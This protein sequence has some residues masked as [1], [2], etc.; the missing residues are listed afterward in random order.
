MIEEVIPFLTEQIIK[1]NSV[2]VHCVYGQSRSAVICAAY[3]ISNGMGFE[4]ALT[5]MKQ[6]HPNICINPGFLSQL[7]IFSHKMKYS[8]QYEM[9]LNQF[10]M[11]NIL[12]IESNPCDQ[13][14]I[15]CNDCLK[16][17]VHLDDIINL[18]DEEET[19]K[20]SI[21]PF[22]DP[23]WS[24]YHSLHSSLSQPCNLP[25]NFVVCRPS[26][27]MIN[28]GQTTRIQKKEKHQNKKRRKDLLPCQSLHCPGCGKVIGGYRHK[29]DGGILVAGGY[30][31]THLYCID[32]SSVIIPNK[33]R[34]IEELQTES[35]E[36]L[37]EV[38]I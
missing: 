23:F 21:M 26:Q 9:I 11:K 20:G 12:P 37:S 15:S 5:H 29:D 22:V 14:M 24:N 7:K 32:Q 8:L 30:V 35:E 17:L 1:K 18:R 38:I 33:I 27:W 6:C 10:P 3:L 19:L 34:E 13:L 16:K 36:D 4:I 2:L 28:E 31:L 25:V